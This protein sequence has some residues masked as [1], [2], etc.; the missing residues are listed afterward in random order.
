MVYSATITT[1]AN[2]A[3]SA[4]KTT[5][6]QATSGVVV[7]SEFYFPPG[8]SGLMGIQVRVAN[9][10]IL[11]IDR[12]EWL[13]GDNRT[14]VID[15]LYEMDSEPFELEVRTY[16]E[17]TDYDHLIQFHTTIMSVDA[18][19]ALHGR[20]ISTDEL[21]VILESITEETKARTEVTLND[22]FGVLGNGD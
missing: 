6:L 1:V 5:T 22:A 14:V 4:P 17:D 8:S 7:R 18:F 10:Q 21:K 13:I 9:V 12:D 19:A 3:P 20:G 16:N 11:P 2:T 15:D